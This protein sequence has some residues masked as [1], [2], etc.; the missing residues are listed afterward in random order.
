LRRDCS[1]LERR[2]SRII[3]R[4][5]RVAGVGGYSRNPGPCVCL[6]PKCSP[7]TKRLMESCE[8]QHRPRG[9]H[10]PANPRRSHLPANHFWQ[11]GCGHDGNIDN[12]DATSDGRIFPLQF[13]LQRARRTSPRPNIVQCRLIRRLRLECPRNEPDLLGSVREDECV[14][15]S[16]IKPHR[17]F[18]STLQP[19]PT[20]R[21]GGSS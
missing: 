4:C 7:T 2:V 6:R 8:R 21:S 19:R 15:A 5:G 11:S 12:Q 18:G 14:A 20:C 9:A 3:R 16:N 13:R 17:D 10:P 1:W